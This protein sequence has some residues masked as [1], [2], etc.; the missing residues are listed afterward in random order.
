M[1]MPAGVAAA[2]KPQPW[3]R[4][5]QATGTRARGMAIAVGRKSSAAS[6]P[7]CQAMAMSVPAYTG[8]AM[9]RRMTGPERRREPMRIPGLTT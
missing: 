6:V 1:R 4:V 8:T 3:L 9:S 5:F 2:R 7:A